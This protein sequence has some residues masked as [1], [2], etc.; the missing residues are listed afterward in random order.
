MTHNVLLK[1][2]KQKN[3]ACACLMSIVYRLILIA[4]AK[5]LLLFIG[6]QPRMNF[7]HDIQRM[8]FISFLTRY[9]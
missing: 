8:N 5:M 1:F 3:R 4:E 6:I 9:S 2:N 7:A